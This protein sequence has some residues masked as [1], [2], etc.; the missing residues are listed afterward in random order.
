MAGAVNTRGMVKHLI[1]L[2]AKAVP[3]SL[4]R[5]VKHCQHV[6]SFVKWR[7]RGGRGG[8]CRMDCAGIT[9][10]VLCLCHALAAIDSRFAALS[11]VSL[12]VRYRLILFQPIYR[13]GQP[14]NYVVLLSLIVF[15]GSEQW[16]FFSRCIGNSIST[17]ILPGTTTNPSFCIS[18]IPVIRYPLYRSNSGPNSDVP[19]TY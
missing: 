1:K 4:P 2:I 16:L 6:W 12:Q 19:C 5:D 18:E 3:K 8:D 17:A 13:L 11:A 9:L 14:E 7:Q 10:T 15:V